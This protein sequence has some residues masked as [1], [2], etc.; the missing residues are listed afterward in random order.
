M[1]Y[2]EQLNNDGVLEITTIPCPVMPTIAFC[3]V[4]SVGIVFLLMALF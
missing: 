1:R 4:L 3:W 2:Q